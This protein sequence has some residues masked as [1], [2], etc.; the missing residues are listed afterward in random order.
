MIS[1]YLSSQ[2]DFVDLLNG[3]LFSKVGL[4]NLFFGVNTVSLYVENGLIK[5][6]KLNVPE[7]LSKANKR[8]LLLYHLFEFM[9]HPFAFFTFREDS[10]EEI[11]NLEDPISAEELILQLQLVHTELRNLLDKVI[12]PLAVVKV[13]KS[14]ENDQYYDGKSIYHILVH[15]SRSLIE[16]IRYLNTLFS[17]GYLDINQFQNPEGLKEEIE[18]DYIMKEV[19]SEKINLINLLESFQLGK[20]TGILKVVGDDFE[21]ELYY[22]RGQ[23]FAI[24]PC[25]PEVFEL[26]LNPKGKSFLNAVRISS[27]MLDLLVLKHAENKVVNGLPT[28]FVEIGKM[29]MSM[30]AENRT[31]VIIIYAGTYKDYIMFKNGA[32]LGIAREDFKEGLK[33]INKISY[34]RVGYVDLIFLQSMEN[35]KDTVH[36][37]LLNVIYGLLLKYASHLNHVVLSQ[38]SSSDV[39]KY[40]EGVILYRKKPKNGD[41]AFSFLQFLLDLSYNVL[42]QERFAQELEIA[43]QPYRD[44]L[45]ILK[46]EEYIRLQ[47][48]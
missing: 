32:L 25:T 47:E 19:E 15:S 37:F 30:S 43:L 35:T 28:S 1:G 4:L 39:L 33:L 20:F 23:L 48:A 22:K 46:V 36:L 8:S 18:F 10:I 17:A 6:F 7:D 13:I 38:L 42:G 16:E 2:Q 5:G 27:N 45:R 41:E 40:E 29:L 26:L 34:E 12:T 44:I 31:G 9:E 14:F 24:Y 3:C 21:Y 11:T